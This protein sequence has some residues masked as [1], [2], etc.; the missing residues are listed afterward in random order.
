[1]SGSIGSFNIPKQKLR[2]LSDAKLA[3]HFT[4]ME[5]RFKQ[6]NKMKFN[7]LLPLDKDSSEVLA[8]PHKTQKE[9]KKI[10]RQVMKNKIG[11]AHAEFI[12]REGSTYETNVSE[13]LGK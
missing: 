6:L 7:C 12:R 8:I 2:G 13:V 9:F 4:Y 1:M 11:E 5:E 10:F 3:M